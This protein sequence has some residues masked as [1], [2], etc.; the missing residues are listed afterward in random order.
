MPSVDG[1]QPSKSA[2]FFFF[3]GGCVAILSTCDCDSL[4]ENTP[5]ISVKPIHN[6]LMTS[7]QMLD[8]SNK[9]PYLYQSNCNE[10]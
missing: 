4:K 2:L 5:N 9:Q 1:H 10:K 7:V 6:L 8:T 3:N